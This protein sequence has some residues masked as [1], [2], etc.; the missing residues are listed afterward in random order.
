MLCVAA[1]FY[2]MYFYV[3]GFFFYVIICNGTWFYCHVHFVRYP[4]WRLVTGITRQWFLNSCVD[5][6]RT[7]CSENYSD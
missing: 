1:K 5:A 4:S 3:V 7:I 6:N 2:G